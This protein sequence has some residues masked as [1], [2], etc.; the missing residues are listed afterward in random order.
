VYF[1]PCRILF[2][3]DQQQY[4]KMEKQKLN[5]FPLVFWVANTMELFERWAYY[6]V[7]ALLSVYLT[8]PRS[9]GGLGFTSEQSGTLMA[10][11]TFTIYFFP[12]FAGAIADRLG[13]RKVM[14]FAFAILATGYYLMGMFTSYHGIFLAFLL[15]GVGAALFKPVIVGTV[16][17]TTNPSNDTVGFGIF[18]MIVNIGAF[19]GPFVASKLRDVQWQYIFVMSAAIILVNFIPLLALYREPGRDKTASQV[20]IWRKLREI[21]ANFFMVL[22]DYRFLAFILIMSGFWV[23]YMQIFFTLP[24]YITQWVDTTVIYNSAGW[25]A[26]VIGKTKNGVGII[27]PEMIQNL[28]A[29]CIVLFQVLMSNLVKGVAPIRSI[30]IGILVSALA[31]AAM[32]LGISGW[33]I[34]IAIVFFTFGEMISSPRTQEY[35]SR[36]APADKVGVYMG[37]S[38]LPIAFGNLIGGFL[39]GKLYS[40]ISDLY[41]FII[42]EL[43]ARGVPY[44]ETIAASDKSII[45]REGMKHLNM[46]SAEM[47][48]YLFNTYEPFRIWWVF[49]AIGLATVVMFLIFNRWVKKRS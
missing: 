2:Y 27:N 34:V 22:A 15:V 4:F 47:K 46:S 25:I 5:R 26:A 35:A 12:M 8:D 33:I 30:T 20:S 10:V 1:C 13:Y 24:V 11:V 6:G 48:T 18:Y 41:V 28:G 42:R 49:G 45:F 44:T 32:S 23:M 3:D 37:F 19:I 40:N 36:I 31:M 14:L 7:F 38:F 9:E 43:E 29:G 16:S 17:K 39:Y 21:K